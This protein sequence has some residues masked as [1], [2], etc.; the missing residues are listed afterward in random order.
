MHFSV[1]Y[2]KKPPYL[3]IRQ[4]L[5]TFA[6]ALIF[7]SHRL[8]NLCEYFYV[9]N[10]HTMPK[11]VPKGEKISL[12]GTASGLILTFS[13]FLYSFGRRSRFSPSSLSLCS[14][15]LRAVLPLAQ[16]SA[17]PRRTLSRASTSYALPNRR[18]AGRRARLS[19]PFSPLAGGRAS[20]V[21]S[22]MRPSCPCRPCVACS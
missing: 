6:S 4:N 16:F 18:Q 1:F 8:R 9:C 10:C 17:T 19:C 20:T 21:M 14:F 15:P 13:S 12:F 7:P 5:R 2:P 11:F 22:E 3:T